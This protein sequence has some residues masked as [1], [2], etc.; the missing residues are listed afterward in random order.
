[1]KKFINIGAGLLILV[2]IAGSFWKITNLN[3]NRNAANSNSVPNST[4]EPSKPVTH[5]DFYPTPIPPDGTDRT[6]ACT[7]DAKICPDGSAVGRTGPDCEFEACPT[8]DISDPIITAC[9]EEMRQAEVCPEI[10]APVCASVQVQCI[11]EPCEPVQETFSNSCFACMNEN[12]SYVTAGECSEV[13]LY[14]Q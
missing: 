14:V 12:V 13:G 5:D 1:M 10:Y 6:V 8:P 11:K 4:Q 9:S 7:M 3:E 2:F